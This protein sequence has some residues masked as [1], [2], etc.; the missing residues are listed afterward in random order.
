MHNPKNILNKNILYPITDTKSDK[1]TMFIYIIIDSI[2]NFY[3]VH[4]SFGFTTKQYKKYCYKYQ[5]RAGFS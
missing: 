1:P 4:Y 2:I 5:V 3:C